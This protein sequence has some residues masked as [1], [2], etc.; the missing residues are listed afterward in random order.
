[1]PPMEIVA[2]QL[3]ALADIPRRD[4]ERLDTAGNPF[5]HYDFLKGLE[6][7]GCLDGHGWRPCHLALKAGGE[8]L[9]AL[10][11]YWRADSHGEFVFDWAW[12]DAY[13]RN[14]LRY[15]P[16]LLS[17]IPFTPV[18]GPRL[19]IRRDAQDPDALRGLLLQAMRQLLDQSG[20]SSWHCLFTNENDRAA[21]ADHGLLQRKTIQFQWR[22]RNYED[23][24]DFLAALTSKRRK[25][26]K[27]ERRQIARQQVRVERRS[28]AEISERQWEVFHRFY[29]STFHRRW[30]SP[31]LTVDFFKSLSDTMPEQ[32][33]LLLARQGQEYVAGVFAMRDEHTLYGRHWGC[34]PRIDCLHFELCYYQTIE[35]CIEHRLAALD[36]GVQGEHKAQR[37]FDPVVA[38][39]GHLIRH[40]GFRR[41][42]A[43]FLRAE[44]AGIDRYIADLRAHS[45]YKEAASKA[46]PDQEPSYTEPPF[47]VS[48][49]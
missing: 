49:Q 24:D 15:Y 25:Q 48:I 37:G 28:G 45:P 14:G 27:R 22:N 46:P 30:G 40:D 10:P 11:L 7:H 9:S 36:A 32:T 39:S 5:L 33:L 42:I 34:G 38:A 17:A 35:Y 1:M 4:W 41:G 3:P 20:A 16:K 8:L 6:E 2:E 18:R 13:E 21:L 44:S 19:L 31:R 43:E 23:F 12:A 47:K 26:I 29:C